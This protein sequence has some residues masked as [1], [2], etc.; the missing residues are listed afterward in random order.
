M[1]LTFKQKLS[2]MAFYGTLFYVAAVGA[3]FGKRGDNE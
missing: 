1:K 3:V 2:W